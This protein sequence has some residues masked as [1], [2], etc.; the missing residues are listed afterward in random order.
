MNEILKNYNIENYEIK[1]MS[2]GFACEKWLVECQNK[3]YILKKM[4]TSKIMRLEFINLVQNVLAKS[5][6]APQIIKTKDNKEYHF[7]D[8]EAY[9]M[10]EYICGESLN[11]QNLSL[12]DIHDIGKLLGKI[13]KILNFNSYE[14]KDYNHNSLSMRCPNIDN[15]KNYINKYIDSEDCIDKKKALKILNYKLKYLNNINYDYIISLFEKYNNTI[16]HGD[17]YT[18]NILLTSNGLICFDLDQTC[19]FPLVYEIY[20]AMS[21]I[22]YDKKYSNKKILTNLREFVLGYNE[23]NIIDSETLYFGLEL[24]IYIT[25][26]S[27]YCLDLGNDISYAE[28]KYQMIKWLEKNKTKVLKNIGVVQ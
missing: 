16:V 21:I 11:K 24:F 18:D 20:R 4:P 19:T 3:M 2:K 1:K 22:C 25:N 9:I 14:L 10:Y 8:N 6:I 27:L 26:N 17:F 5:K 15:I 7:F 23:E 12:K 13:H 28:Y